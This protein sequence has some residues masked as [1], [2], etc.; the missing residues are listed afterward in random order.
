MRVAW[1]TGAGAR[2]GH[3]RPAQSERGKEQEDRLPVHSSKLRGE[4]FRRRSYGSYCKENLTQPMT[5]QAKEHNLGQIL[6]ASRQEFLDASAGLSEPQAQT[7]PE[8]GRWS[9]CE[10][11][12]H[13]AIV[14]ERFL[15]FLE[16]GERA[17]SPVIDSQKEAGLIEKVPNRSERVQAPEMVHPTGRFATL[18]EAL[19]AFDAVRAR[20]LAFA[21]DRAA[22]LPSLG[23]AH[24]RFGTAARC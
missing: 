11:V 8:E 19:Q 1:F 22:D 4:H 12:E 23:W 3:T 9:V 2:S 18:A 20:T 21:Q 15:G 16:K 14:E 13:V 5:P 7:K 6:E 24:P 17:E 10:C